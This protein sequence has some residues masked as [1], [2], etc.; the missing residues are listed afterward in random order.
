VEAE[1]MAI[2]LLLGRFHDAGRVEIGKETYVDDP[3]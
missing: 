3:R 1:E 2:S